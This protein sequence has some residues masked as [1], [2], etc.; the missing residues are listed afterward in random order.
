MLIQLKFSSIIESSI[1]LRSLI[2]IQQID[3]GLQSLND[4]FLQQPVMP[5][6]EILMHKKQL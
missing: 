1:R 4:Q 6:S 2:R 3:G 5:A